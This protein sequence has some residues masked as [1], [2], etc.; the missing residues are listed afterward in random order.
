[1]DFY[2]ELFQLQESEQQRIQSEHCVHDLKTVLDNKERELI[3]SSKK[4]QDILL[5][6][7]GT[8]TT[9]KQLEEH[10]QR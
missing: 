4:L 9:I 5:S 8:N 2:C 7:S 3:A 10:V 1:M 6:S